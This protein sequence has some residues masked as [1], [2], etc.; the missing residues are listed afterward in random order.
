MKHIIVNFHDFAFDQEIL[1]YIDGVCEKQ[2]Q[3]PVSDLTNVVFGL[4]DLYNITQIDMC[5][6]PEYLSKFKA[7]LL[8]KYSNTNL[9]INII[10]RR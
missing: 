1:V 2:M 4:S 5:G 10:K 7:E 9:E 6:N 3:V 8:T